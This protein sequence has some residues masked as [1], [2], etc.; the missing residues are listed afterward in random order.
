[1][2]KN[3]YPICPIC[4]KRMKKNIFKGYLFCPKVRV[5]REKR[6]G[7]GYILDKNNLDL[8]FKTYKGEK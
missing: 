3:K 4:N 6:I 2:I 5:G 7:C 8:E 1:M